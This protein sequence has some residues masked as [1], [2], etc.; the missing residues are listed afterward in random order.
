MARPKGIE[1][2]A[3]RARRFEV[4][5]S[6][7]LVNVDGLS[8]VN[9]KI[10]REAGDHV[11]SE[12]A[13]LIR[14]NVRLVDVF[15]RWQAED[16]MVMTLDKNQFGSVAL[17]EKLRKIISDHE[18]SYEG[19]E[20]NVTVSIGVARGIPRSEAEIDD[21]ISAA[22]TAVLRAKSSGRNRVEYAG[23]GAGLKAS[24]KRD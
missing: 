16:F 12:V 22:K 4:Q 19:Q 14:S 11:L 1:V 20:F 10:G 3:E 18:F 23:P 15:G 24:G 21:M 9:Q 17:A 13:D 7:I 2:E 8:V 5:L 6:V